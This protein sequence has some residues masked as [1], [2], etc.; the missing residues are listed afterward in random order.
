MWRRPVA[1]V[2]ERESDVSEKTFDRAAHMRAIAVQGRAVKAQ[3]LALRKLSAAVGDVQ[4][5]GATPDP[6]TTQALREL[7][8]RA[9]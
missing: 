3:N 9:S 4:R 8:S 2:N 5:T 1:S 7:L 6:E